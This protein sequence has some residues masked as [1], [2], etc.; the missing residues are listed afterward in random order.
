M[1]EPT[2]PLIQKLIARLRDED[3]INRRN[4]A[5]A[6]RLHGRRATAAAAE[7]A[8]L[9]AD[10]DPSVRSEARRALERLRTAAA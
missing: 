6:L 2:D 7:L 4:A 10:E 9:L 1:A 8:M 3:P 5:G